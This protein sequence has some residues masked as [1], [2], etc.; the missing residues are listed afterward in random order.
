MLKALVAATCIAVI[1]AVGYYFFREYSADQD[2]QRRAAFSIAKA[3]C[4]EDMRA[5]LKRGETP[6][7]ALHDRMMNCLSSGYFTEAE[8]AE[9][10]QGKF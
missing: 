2:R 5:W 1:A 7:T 9:A 10:R 6:E 3:S 4:D 8:M